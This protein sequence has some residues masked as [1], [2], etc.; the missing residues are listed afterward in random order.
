MRP[1]AFLFAA[2][3]HLLALV[4]GCAGSKPQPTADQTLYTRLGG[5]EAISAVV[6][7]FLQNVAAD[8]RI[9][10]R[11]ATAD[12]PDLRQKLIDQI[13]QATGG[14]CHYQGKD[15]KTA[16]AGMNL[17]GADFN[18]LVEDLTKA[19]DQFHVPEQE[20]HELLTALGSM[21]G[22]IVTSDG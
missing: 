8:D 10:V 3:W 4:A 1:R 16:H 6:G 22:D 14:P 7:A 18:A 20:K 21:R 13:C 17:T 2:A 5:K 11:F 12:L 15:M 9:N 19:L